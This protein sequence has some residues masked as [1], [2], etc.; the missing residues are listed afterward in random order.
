MLFGSNPNFTSWGPFINHDTFIVQPVSRADFAT[1]I[2]AFVLVIVF[3]TS[4]AYVGYRQTRRSREPWKS[5]YI[6]MVWLEWASCLIIG[7]EC[8]LFIVRAVRPSFYF[9]MSICQWLR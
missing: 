6:W 7:I 4:A 8:M 2:I 5:A 1:A 9:F 3:A